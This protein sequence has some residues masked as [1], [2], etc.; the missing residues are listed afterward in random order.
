VRTCSINTGTNSID[1]ELVRED[2]C[3][4]LSLT[5]FYGLN[6]SITTSMNN[7]TTKLNRNMFSGC[8]S[9]CRL[10]ECNHAKIIINNLFLI[11]LLLFYNL[12]Y[13]V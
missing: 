8:L 2:Y 6:V 1:T 3:G 4:Y 9:V 7:L 12:F 11:L 13:V 10:N 5:D